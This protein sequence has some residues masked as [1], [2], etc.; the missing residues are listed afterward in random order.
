[1]SRD[2]ALMPGA[3]SVSGILHVGPID[4]AGSGC[5]SMVN[6]VCN[7]EVRRH[8]DTPMSEQSTH[9]NRRCALVGS[10]TGLIGSSPGSGLRPIKVHAEGRRGICLRNTTT[11]V[12]RRAPAPYNSVNSVTLPGAALMVPDHCL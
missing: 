4:R 7:S 5:E 3:I 9:I 1:M 11:K 2:R 6:S 8:I 10:M 12:R